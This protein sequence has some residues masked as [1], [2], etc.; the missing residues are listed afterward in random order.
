MRAQRFAPIAV[1]AACAAGTAIL[2][3]CG[4]SETPAA[5]LARLPAEVGGLRA[6]GAADAHPAAAIFSYLDGGAEVYLA[7][8]LH[9]CHVRRY[10]VAGL[11]VIV[12]VFD[13]GSSADA[14]GVFS[15]D[16][17]GETVAVGQGAR[18]RP[19]WLSAWKGRFY[20]SI[21]ADR[22]DEAARRA[23]LDLGRAVASAIRSEGPPPALLRRLP[24]NGLD[25]ERLAY[26]HDHVT[27]ATLVAL[28][29]GNP[30]GLGKATEVAVG[31]YRRG[32]AVVTLLLVRHADAAAADGAAERVAQAWGGAPG[33]A[34][35]DESGRWRAAAAQGATV[36]VVVGSDDEESVHALLADALS[37]SGER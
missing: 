32:A 27:L 4:G 18:L 30:L 15:R 34:R 5:V 20:V 10:A 3:S 2:V 23:L 22:D 8:N 13:M 28:P 16:L 25:T 1:A 36:A 37:E 26:A 19:G 33:V 12:D 17:D 21:T 24:A 29:D 35:R 6:A 9:S 14:F 7:Y 31:R 11:E